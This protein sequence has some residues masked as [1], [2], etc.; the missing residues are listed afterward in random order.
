MAV[1]P[2]SGLAGACNGRL[3]DGRGRRS[4]PPPQ[5]RR[6]GGRLEVRPGVKCG[7]RRGQKERRDLVES[8]SRQID[9]SL[10]LLTLTGRECGSRRY[11]QGINSPIYGRRRGSGP[12]QEIFSLS[13]TRK[14]FKYRVAA[15]SGPNQNRRLPGFENYPNPNIAECSGF[16]N[17]SDGG[18]LK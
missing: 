15:A 11:G 16:L 12:R 3:R 13:P 4:R 8:R 17:H 6:S 7:I 9:R 5:G 14:T 2:E 10:W 1:Q 18:L